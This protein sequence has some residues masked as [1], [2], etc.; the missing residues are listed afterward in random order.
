MIKKLVLSK[1]KRPQGIFTRRFLNKLLFLLNHKIFPSR[2]ERRSTNTTNIY[3]DV[4]GISIF[5]LKTGVQRAVKNILQELHN[6]LPAGFNLV[7]V[8][9]SSAL[10]GFYVV[11]IQLGEQ[12]KFT[13]TNI[14]ISPRQGDIFLS[15]ETALNEHINQSDLLDNFRN[16]GCKIFFVVHDLLPILLPN[17][18][19]RNHRNNFI[20]WLTTTSEYSNYICVSRTTKLY[21]ESWLR[22]NNKNN[23]CFNYRVG[24]NFENN[25]MTKGVTK[26]EKESITQIN[27]TKYKFLMVGTIE[28]RKQNLFV[29]KEF[30]K[31]W[32][33]GLKDISLIFVGK[34][35]WMCEDAIDN[36][37]QH[38]LLGE[39]FFHFPSASDELLQYLYKSST[40]L[41]Y[42]S[43]NEGFGLPLIEAA[44]YGLPI[45]ARDKPIYHEVVGNSAYYFDEEDALDEVVKEWLLLFKRNLHPKSQNIPAVTWEETAKD[46]ID[47]ICKR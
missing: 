11:N 32:E 10:K 2:D 33:K 30:N 24:Y 34:I 14:K 44:H 18:F 40:A 9:C 35:G 42:A 26:K 28:P 5:D 39:N 13:H 47:I 22:E 12:L 21:L 19:T 43:L 46:I 8:A 15:V 16:K 45:I 23:K 41:I 29:L 25:L 3:Y 27:K 37:K 38:P 17:C 4:S 7:P 20:E 36:F 31:L 1:I 6:N